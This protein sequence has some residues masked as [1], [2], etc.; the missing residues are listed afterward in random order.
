MGD[1]CAY[2]PARSGTASKRGKG[3]AAKPI[4]SGAFFLACSA[5]HDH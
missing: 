1:D 3:L 2:G 5:L 4:Y